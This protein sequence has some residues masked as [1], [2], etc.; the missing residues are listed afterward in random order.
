MLK[1]VNVCIHQSGQPLWLIPNFPERT[2]RVLREGRSSAPARRPAA[3]SLREAIQPACVS[4]DPG[5]SRSARTGLHP[6]HVRGGRPLQQRAAGGRRLGRAR[7]CASLPGG[8]VTQPRA[9]ALR[10]APRLTRRARAPPRPADDLGG[11]GRD[12]PQQGG[13]GGEGG[14][15]EHL[16]EEVRRSSGGLEARAGRRLEV[17]PSGAGARRSERQAWRL[18]EGEGPG[19]G[20][21]PRAGAPPPLRQRPRRLPA[22]AVSDR[23]TSPTS[24]SARSPSSIERASSS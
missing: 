15:A 18:A 14:G 11:V 16:R 4:H 20:V 17:T 12:G 23:P 19:R 22:V 3:P 8:A 13:A 21:R 7:R 2:V 1:Q 24:T 10:H 5:R 9:T 6:P